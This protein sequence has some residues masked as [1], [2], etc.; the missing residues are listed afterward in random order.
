M[1]LQIGSA[2]IESIRHDYLGL[3]KI[4]CRWVPHFLTEAQ[5]QDHVDYYL[6]MLKKFDG[7]RSKRLYDIITGD[8]SC[9][10]YYDSEMKRQSQV[11]VARNDP[12]SKQ[13]SWTTF[14]W[15]TYVCNFLYEIRF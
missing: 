8:E 9:F 4:T 5:K 10:Y 11:W 15:Q 2:A 14:C 13:S 6:P 7:G 1:T 3:R 12:S